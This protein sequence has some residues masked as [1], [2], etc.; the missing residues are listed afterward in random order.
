MKMGSSL[1]L[2]GIGR[3]Y[4]RAEEKVMDQK[5]PFVTAMIVVRNEE[6]YIG[7][8]VASLLKQNYPKEYFELLII[9]GDSEDKTLLE[10]KHAV[11]EYE[12]ECG[13]V[14][15]HYLENPKKILAAGWN[16]GIKKAKGEYVVRIDAHAQADPELINKCIQIL[17]EKTDVVC[18]GGRIV[19]EPLTEKGKL[20]ADVMSSPF[21]VG[22]ARF[23]YAETSGYVDT[24]AYGVYRKSIFEKAGYFNESFVRNQDN[25]M[26][27]RIKKCGGK[28]Y[29]EASITSTYHA[30]EN[31]KGMMKQAF[32]NGKWSI[33]GWRKS[34]SKKGISLRHMVPLCFVL[35]NLILC[36]AGIFHKEFRAI[37]IAMYLSYFCTAIYYALKKTK[38]IL[39]VI[40][41]CG[42][43][44]ILHI[45]YGIG[46]LSEIFIGRK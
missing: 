14:Q 32:G 24:V 1:R 8:A 44:W 43:Y 17:N 22:N 23:R 46:S 37:F 45:S 18:A 7:K 16:I 12:S 9:D 34:E 27:G 13:S 15:V 3:I 31:I 30:R 20:I 11:G 35:G 4:K 6:K 2:T 40:E 5:Q 19:T 41:M 29:L 28:F 38:N 26:H 39:K 42:C 36:I 10:A 33:I 25:D 21:G